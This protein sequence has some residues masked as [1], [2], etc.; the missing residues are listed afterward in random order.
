LE[1][2][3][4]ELAEL[5]HVKTEFLATTSHELRTPLNSILGFTR[6]I[7]DGCAI[8]AMRNGS[9]FATSI[10]A[11]SICFSIVNDLLDVG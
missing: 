10:P 4:L 8:A 6:L 5:S 7:L 3:N 11:P 9:C 2:A 1:R